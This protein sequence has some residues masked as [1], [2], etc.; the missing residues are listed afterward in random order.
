M[1][2]VLVMV[3]VLDQKIHVE[4]LEVRSIVDLP[5]SDLGLCG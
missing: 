2:L 4:D 5:V 3:A 1:M